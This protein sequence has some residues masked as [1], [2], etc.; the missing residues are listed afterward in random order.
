[1]LDVVEKLAREKSSTPSQPTV[2]GC[3]GQPA[4]TSPI[5]GPWATELCRTTRAR[6]RES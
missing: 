3:A 1:M 4:V 6:S 5:T 2:A